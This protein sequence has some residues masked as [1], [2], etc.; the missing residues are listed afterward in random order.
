MVSPWFL[1]SFFGG[2]SKRTTSAGA[3]SHGTDLGLVE[4][5][6]LVPAISQ[7]LRILATR[8]GAL[9]KKLETIEEPEENDELIRKLLGFNRVECD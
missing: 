5:D 9:T 7:S 6:M 8:S 4:M 2:T 3:K 1:Y